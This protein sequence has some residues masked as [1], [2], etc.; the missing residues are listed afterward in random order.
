MA[1]VFLP[2]VFHSFMLAHNALWKNV[3]AA[4]FLVRSNRGQIAFLTLCE[5]LCLKIRYFYVA[6]LLFLTIIFYHNKKDKISNC[7]L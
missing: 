5:S 1:M 3:P 6:K 4:I 2:S 7:C